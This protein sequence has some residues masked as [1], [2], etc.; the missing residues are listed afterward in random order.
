MITVNMAISTK[1]PTTKHRAC[2]LI[3]VVNRAAIV[4]TYWGLTL[5]TL[6]VRTDAGRGAWW[7]IALKGGLLWSIFKSCFRPFW[8]G[9]STVLSLVFVL[10][11]GTVSLSIPAP[12]TTLQN[13]SEAQTVLFTS[14]FCP[15]WAVMVSIFQ[16][17]W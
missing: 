16:N 10:V 8:T 5:A 11:C 14:V 6:R 7:Q 3:E 15:R 12:Q 2:C 17:G 13:T 4:H 1:M 9:R